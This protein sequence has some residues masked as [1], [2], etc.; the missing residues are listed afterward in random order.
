MDIWRIHD[1][2]KRH[3]VDRAW[4]DVVTARVAFDNELNNVRVVPV[5]DRVAKLRESFEAL[6]ASIKA[7]Q[8][9]YLFA[10]YAWR[11]MNAK[12]RTT[13]NDENRDLRGEVHRLRAEMHRL[14][15]ESSVD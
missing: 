10:A 8:D 4:E 9:A 12:L 15:S 5:A 14:R 2:E 6:C 7:Y 3:A 11:D 13:V 1:D